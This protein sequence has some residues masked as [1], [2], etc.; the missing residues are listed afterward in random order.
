LRERGRV[1]VDRANYIDIRQSAGNPSDANV[2]EDDVNYLH[3]LRKHL[4]CDEIVDLFE[5]YDV[6]V[7]YEYDRTHEN[8]PDEYW[9]KCPDLGM[10][11]VFDDQQRLKMVYLV[12][13]SEEGFTPASLT[14]SDIPRFAS[15]QEAVQHARRNGIDMTVGRTEFQG[16]DTN[17]IRFEYEGHSIHYEFQD[18]RL[19]LVTLE[20]RAA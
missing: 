4:K 8:L 13:T 9:A 20:T 5:T 16:V 6:E 18:G 17:W 3:L 7:V 10:Q 14:G 19:G 12:L 2:G 15:K 1:R 11:L